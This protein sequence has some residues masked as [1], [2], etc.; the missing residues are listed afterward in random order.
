MKAVPDSARQATIEHYARWEKKKNDARRDVF[1]VFMNNLQ[2][3]NGKLLSERA[4][5]CCNIQ[6]RKYRGAQ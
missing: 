3:Q 6:E 2:T 5:C 4:L 1:Y